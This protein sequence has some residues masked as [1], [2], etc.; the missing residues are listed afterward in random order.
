MKFIG[1]KFELEELNR[2]FNEEGFSFSVIY[3]RRRVGKTFLIK[4]FLNDK[5]GY[6]FVALESNE[7][8]NLNLLS[9][10]IYKA[11]GGISGL[12]DFNSFENAFKFL[13]EY[14]VKSKLIFVIDE[15]PY[16]AE[17]SPYVSSL[18]QKLI[19]EYKTRSKLFL[20][21]CGSSMSFMEEQVLGYKS[22]LYGRRTSQ[23]KINPFNYLESAEF[24]PKYSYKDK[25][26]VYALTNGIAEYLTYFDEN[27]SLKDNI[28]NN[29]L[30]AN[31]RL[32]DE[33]NN[34]LKQELRQPKTYNDILYSISQGASKLNEISNKINLASGSLS[35]YLNALISLGIIERK[36]PVLNR[37]TKRPVY[38]IKDTMYLFW[39]NFVQPNLNIIN[40]GM[41]D[42]VYKNSVET[43][44]NNYMG[45]V[46]EKISIEY[47]EELI[48]RKGLEFFPEDYGNW[49]GNDKRLKMQ[50]EIDLLAYDKS[51]N[52]LFLEAKWRNEPV[53]EN[54]LEGLIEKSLNFNFLK[55]NYMITSLSGYNIKQIPDN[56]RLIELEDMYFKNK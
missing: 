43:N 45:E 29:F 12:P 5:P 23:F 15:Y 22:P 17:S 1:R 28:I 9:Q 52:Y 25:A 56:V 2:E 24:V 14:S 46:F 38:K 19:D 10:A 50:S 48:K 39:Y 33:A 20:I 35:Y 7:V 54:V 6:Y 44:I 3:G 51:K 4:E 49:W 27:K 32:Y 41:S 21:L 30:K 11:C 36:T 47:F 37:K 53:K 18:I 34:L 26:I 55:A 8:I 13:F 40:L 16:L 31:G 42:S